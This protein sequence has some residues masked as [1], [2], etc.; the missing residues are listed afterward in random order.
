MSELFFFIQ[1]LLNRDMGEKMNYL[2]AGSVLQ[3]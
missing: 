3:L 2:G 1:K